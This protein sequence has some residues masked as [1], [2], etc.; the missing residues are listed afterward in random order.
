MYMMRV[1]TFHT[2]LV[3]WI[4]VFTI[5]AS[6]AKIIDFSQNVLA[7]PGISGIY[8]VPN[9]ELPYEMLPVTQN[10]PPGLLVSVGTERAFITAAINPKAV[11]HVLMLDYDLENVFYNQM[12][13]AL[14]QASHDRKDYL[15]LRLSAS[16]AV[17]QQRARDPR[18][19]V[20]LR[21]LL[22]SPE[23][24]KWWQ[25]EVRVNERM[26]DFHSNPE[27]FMP[28][29][30]RRKRQ[31]EE[32]KFKSSNYIWRDDLFSRVHQ[33]A[34]EGKLQALQLDFSNENEVEKVVEALSKSKAPKLSILDLSNAWWSQYIG[35]DQTARALELFKPVS[36][37]KS[38]L[39]LTQIAQSQRLVTY[40][41]DWHYFGFTF[42]KLF[43]GSNVRTFLYK[44]LP[45]DK[46][47]RLAQGP[48]LNGEPLAPVQ[49]PK[50]QGCILGLVKSLLT[51]VR[52]SSE[53][54]AH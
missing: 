31:L 41:N 20:E 10:A 43:R 28:E 11:T 33:L 3:A 46:S 42:D 54:S 26:R 7:T 53:K 52:R 25:R 34:R 24:W 6:E 8:M 16:P 13:I 1:F 32:V 50:R 21:G 22:S 23:N 18:L 5:L 36:Q 37:S 19:P 30:K 49:P 47:D 38:L 4:L 51:N 45:H 12:N 9:E 15:R 39:L 48:M 40:M 29:I 17:W 44:H 35:K 14:L 2:F 27:G